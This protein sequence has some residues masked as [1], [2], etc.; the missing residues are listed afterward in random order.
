MYLLVFFWGGVN[1]SMYICIRNQLYS[2]IDMRYDA[3]K[4]INPITTV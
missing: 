1:K 4:N 3:E 2:I